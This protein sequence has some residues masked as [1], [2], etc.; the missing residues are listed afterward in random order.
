MS[1]NLRVMIMAGG[2]GG[3]VFP[4]LAVAEHLRT[5]DARI[6]WLG[7]R[8]GLESDLVP[9]HGIDIDYM[10][11]EGIRGRGVGALLKAPILLWRSIRQA[12]SVLA[13]FK[14][15][16]VLGMGGFASGP[17]A[18]AARLKGIPVV[19]HEQNS[20]A[21]TTNRLSALIATRVMQ[22]FPDTLKGGEWC[23]N[24]VRPAIA[25]LAPPQ[26]R[27]AKRKGAT[28]LLIL[29]GSRGALAINSMLPK[30]LARIDSSVRPEVIHQ[31]GK[32]HL[33]ATIN[34]YQKL[35]LNVKNGKIN[36]VAFIDGME[37]AYGWADFVICRAGALTV[38]E[39]TSAGLG[40][41]LIPFP[42]AIDDHQTSNGQLLVDQGA[43]TMLQQSQLTPEI[44]ANE[45]N[46][47]CNRPKQRLNM[48]MCTRELAKNDAAQAVARVCL[49]VANGQ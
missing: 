3:H 25:N 16:V 41:L 11:I 36:V 14:P 43:A 42:F 35:G 23:G 32:A 12:L 2:T 33:Q 21:G 4:A 48:A 5:A 17:G 40:S 47:I 45:I 34:D 24:P 22:G 39:L 38:A 15:Q 8:R 29:G 13:E 30:A 44:L 28:K 7:T 26:K 46:S 37:D 27:L 20:V 31:T 6:S 18:V 9:S 1:D 19:I 49:E 10:D